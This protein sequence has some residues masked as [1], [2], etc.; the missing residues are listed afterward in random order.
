MIIRVSCFLTKLSVYKGFTYS[1]Q[2]LSNEKV[3]YS[4]ISGAFFRNAE[5]DM[6]VSCLNTR[7]NVAVELKPQS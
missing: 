3:A 2:D 1:D 7:W 6:P 4:G 5:G